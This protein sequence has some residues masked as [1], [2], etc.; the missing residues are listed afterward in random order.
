METANSL[1]IRLEE[2]A[3]DVSARL[4]KNPRIGSTR[5]K[6]A[7]WFTFEF[8]SNADLHD[9]L[10]WLNRAYE[11]AGKGNQSRKCGALVIRITVEYTAF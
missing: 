4:K 1:G 8:S 11:A 3:A 9:A 5:M 10:D 2:P 7:R 6:R